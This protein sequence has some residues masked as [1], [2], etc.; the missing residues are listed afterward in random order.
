MQR[1][2]AAGVPSQ[3]GRQ[4][5]PLGPRLPRPRD[6]RRCSASTSPASQA[7]MKAAWWH[8]CFSPTGQAVFL[9]PT[10]LLFSDVCNL[11]E[12][13][14]ISLRGRGEESCQGLKVSI[15]LLKQKDRPEPP[16]GTRQLS[17]LH[18]KRPGLCSAQVSSGTHAW[19]SS[20]P[21]PARMKA[22]APHSST[23]A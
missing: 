7:P 11:G 21:K 14:A 9:F 5:R 10:F 18:G 6:G 3:P 12:M 19:K 1:R 16:P 8:L 20:T 22:M 15:P 13:C 23:L 4:G 17:L 2:A